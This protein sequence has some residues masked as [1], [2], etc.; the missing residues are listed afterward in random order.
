MRPMKRLMVMAVTSVALLGC[1]AASQYK[2][3]CNGSRCDAETSGPA[4]L[5]LRREFGK[6]LEVIET[7]DN[8]VTIEVGSQRK[9]FA[10]GDTGTLDS[11]HIEVTN[12]KGEQAFFNVRGG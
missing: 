7:A 1:G 9:T 11:L 10:M 8:R 4:A 6:T 3:T 12:V 5:D 2:F